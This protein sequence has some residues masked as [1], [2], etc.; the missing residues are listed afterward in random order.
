LKGE[1]EKSGHGTTLVPRRPDSAY[2]AQGQIPGPGAYSPNL[3]TKAKQ[4]SYRIG[5][6]SRDGLS[7]EYAGI[8]GPGQ[9]DPKLQKANTNIRFG[10]STRKPLADSTTTPGPGAYQV[11][12][13][14]VEGPKYHMA[15]KA[16][17]SSFNYSKGIPG[18]GAY[19]PSIN[20]VKDKQPSFG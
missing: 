4:P 15:S 19:S 5:S 17:D 13:K 18:P 16:G 14:V 12:N 9:Y 10:S 3:V 6:A 1:F 11:P 8:P 2:L 7:K 20:F